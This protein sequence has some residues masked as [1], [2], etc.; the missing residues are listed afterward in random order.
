VLQSANWND[1]DLNELLRKKE[2]LSRQRR[3]LER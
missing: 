2:E 3:S 1:G